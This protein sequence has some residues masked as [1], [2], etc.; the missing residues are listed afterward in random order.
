MKNGKAKNSDEKA[1]TQ[2]EE[3]AAETI[4]SNGNFKDELREPRWSVV[5]FEKVAANNLTY[6]EAARKIAELEKQKVSGLCLIT[7]EAAERISGE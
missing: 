5:S 3:T 1:T 7:D 2:N 4:S 6:N